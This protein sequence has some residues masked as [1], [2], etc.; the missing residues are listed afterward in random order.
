[1]ED[2]DYEEQIRPKSIVYIELR[3]LG[4]IPRT[5]GPRELRNVN[6][7]YNP[8][9]TDQ[10]NLTLTSD[11]GD[12]KTTN[13]A[14]IGPDRDKW[15]EAIKKEITNFMSRV[16]WKPVSRKKVVEE[17]KYPLSDL[18]EENITR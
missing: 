2:S 9:F 16:V 13:E 17:M 1:V 8:T 6:T 12:P 5:S 15:I 3:S 7:S 10:V 11:P 4:I 18:Y 14:L